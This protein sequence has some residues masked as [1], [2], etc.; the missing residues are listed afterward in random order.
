EHLA[1]RDVRG[2]EFLG[3]ARGL[4]PLADAGRP[5]EQKIQPAHRRMNPSYCR[6]INCDSICFIVSSD[7]PTTINRA[8]PPKNTPGML[9]T[10]ANTIGNTAAISAKN[11]EPANVMRIS[12]RSKNSVVGL[13]GRMPGM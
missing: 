5:H 8:V 4:R 3:Q 1:G 2:A 6:I 7:T 12:T 11:S 9:V 13:P 10:A